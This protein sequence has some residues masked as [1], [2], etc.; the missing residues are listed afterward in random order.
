MPVRQ[1]HTRQDMDRGNR[2]TQAIDGPTVP[3]HGDQAAG[4]LTL[5]RMVVSSKEVMDIV[6][7]RLQP[8]MGATLRKG[9]RR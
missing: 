2:L 6:T 4:G 5:S 9:R 1:R 8:A 7:Y 3:G